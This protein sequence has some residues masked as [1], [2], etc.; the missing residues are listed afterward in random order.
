MRVYY[1]WYLL[2]AAIIIAA[3]SAGVRD[4]FS[5][6]IVH[7]S[8]ELGWNI[9]AAFGGAHFTGVLVNGL[10]QPIF[11]H[12]IDSRDARKVILISVAV[13]GLATVSL[14]F[15]Y[16]TWHLFVLFGILFSGAM[17]GVS[18]GVLGPLAARWFLKRRTLALSLLTAA[19]TMGSIFLNQSAFIVQYLYGWQAA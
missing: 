5:V 16:Y 12:L 10:T 17:G 3:A 11:G 13:A 19:S 7:M 6:F 9:A 2:V 8:E 15:I 1:G 14:G 4:S 18:F